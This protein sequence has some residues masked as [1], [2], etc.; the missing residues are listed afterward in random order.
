[1]T[2]QTLAV[3]TLIT[4]LAS[5]VLAAV[6][7]GVDLARMND[8]DI[9]VAEDALSSETYAAEEFR[10][11]FERASGVRLAINHASDRPDRH[12]FIGPSDLMR[13]S[14]GGFDV[15]AMGDEDLR[16]VVREPCICIAGGRPR[17]TLY[18]VYTF[19]EDYLGVRFLTH[20]HT[21]VQP[22]AEWRIVGPVDRTYRP[23]LSFRW[24]YYGETNQRPVFAARLRCNTVTH[25]QKLGGVTGTILI[26]H[27]F[28]NL[29][30]TRR[31]GEEHPEYFS[32]VDGVRRADVQHDAGGDGNE[33]CLTNPHVLPIVV[34]ST[35]DQI[36]RHPQRTNVSVTQ[37]DNAHYCRCDN[38]AALDERE[39]TPMGSLLTFVNAVAAKVAEKHPSVR[40]GTLAYWYSRRPPRTLK[41]APNV[42]IQ[43]A[44]IECSILQPINDADSKLNAPF[45]ADMEGWGRIC[46]DINVWNYNTNFSNYLLP[47]PNLRVIEPNVRFFVANNVHGLFMQAA[48][49]ALGAELSDLRNYVMAR[50]IWD[51]NQSGQALIDEFLNLHYG[52][53]APPIRRFINLVHDNAEARGIEKNC[54]A[55]AKDYGID[56]AIVK[57]GLDAFD[58]ALR[59]A[60][61]PTVRGRVEK[62]SVCAHRAAIEDA[63]VWAAEHKDELGTV[64]M[65]ADLAARTRPHVRRLFEL[66]DRHGVTRWNEYAAIDAQREVFRHAFGLAD[67]EEF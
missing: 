15:A 61:D 66:C 55:S 54:F 39:G 45:C 21:H 14:P 11:H 52:A 48:G 25:D 1:M 42:M 53:A 18:G 47:C 28:T 40:V 13:A 51:P 24:P 20:D 36:E 7:R 34:Q 19:L 33:P 6:P 16:I 43:L 29:I 59:L 9:I 35:L 60:P 3:A 30:P 23:A 63:A 67:G 57:A 17:G 56:E 46:G 27:S 4:G 26:N 65:P 10:D 2:M 5:V 50:L 58:E 38:C 22:V 44:S 31:Y 37:N 41:P 62:A 8:W 64:A 49:N 32:L 12:V